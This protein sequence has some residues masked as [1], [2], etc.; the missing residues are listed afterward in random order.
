MA[1]RIFT[2]NARLRPKI[3]RVADPISTD[4]LK[5]GLPGGPYVELAAWDADDIVA[6]WNTISHG[7]RERITASVLSNDVLFTCVAPNEDFHIRATIAGAAE[8]DLPIVSEHQVGSGPGYFM[9]PDNWA[10]QTVPDSED[11]IIIDNAQAPILWDLDLVQQFAYYDTNGGFARFILADR[12]KTFV[13]NQKLRVQS[14]VTLPTGLTA[15]YVWVKNP[16]GYGRFQLSTTADDADRLTTSAAGSGVHRIGLH[17]VNVVVYARFAG[18]QIGLPIRRANSKE[19]L[20]RSLNCWFERLVIG[21]GFLGGNGL[22]FGSFDCEDAPVT[23]GLIV[24][25]TSNSNSN[26]PAVLIKTNN[27]ATVL[28]QYGGDV[29]VAVYPDETAVMSHVE[30]NGGRILLS[31]TTCSNPSRFLGEYKFYNSTIPGVSNQFTP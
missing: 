3:L 18:S 23:N 12:K 5:I 9:H 17:D 15:G 6:A 19:Y 22:T 28:Q 31:N 4:D 27:S 24:D 29:G 13:H 8:T 25:R 20:P 7:L 10:D 11:T 16:D 1:T 2:G 26:V 30:Q 21:D 14:T